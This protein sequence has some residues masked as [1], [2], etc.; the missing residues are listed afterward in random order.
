VAPIKRV[1]TQQDGELQELRRINA[2]MRRNEQGK[3]QSLQQLI[4]LGH[5]RRMNNPVGWAKHVYAARQ[6]A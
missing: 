4:A 6:R 5:A 2:K 1:I 3:A